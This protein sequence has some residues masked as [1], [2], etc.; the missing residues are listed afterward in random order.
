MREAESQGHT[1]GSRVRITPLLPLFYHG[2]IQ[3]MPPKDID[4]LAAFSDRNRWFSEV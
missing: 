2:D 1:G 3:D 4:S